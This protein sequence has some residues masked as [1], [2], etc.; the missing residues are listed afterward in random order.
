ML[1]RESGAGH[2]LFTLGAM[3]IA[4]RRDQQAPLI[5]IEIAKCRMFVE[6]APQVRFGA[7]GEVPSLAACRFKFLQELV[8]RELTGGNK[9]LRRL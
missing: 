6:M 8:I 1:L 3:A 4:V 9:H 7:G 5:Q 2:H